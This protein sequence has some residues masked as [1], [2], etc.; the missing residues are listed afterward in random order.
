MNKQKRHT[1]KAISVASAGL[2][3]AS[4]I[5]FA[6]TAMAK[7][8]NCESCTVTIKHQW[9]NGINKV[10]LHN[11]TNEEVVVDFVSPRKAHSANG[12]FSIELAAPRG[13]F[14]IAPGSEREFSVLAKTA[15]KNDTLHFSWVKDLIK[16]KMKI[17]SSHPSFAN[18]TPITVFDPYIS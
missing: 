15:N 12:R 2:A 4:A 13:Q 11:P 5:P 10:V 7:T 17:H 6:A 14:S 8:M 1:L 16:D 9:A 18:V 3:A